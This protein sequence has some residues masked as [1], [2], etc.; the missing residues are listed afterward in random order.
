MAL[1]GAMS[2]ADRARLAF[3]DLEKL[4][5]AEEVQRLSPLIFQAV[6]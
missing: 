2:S 4:V 3:L 1:R 6:A 5:D